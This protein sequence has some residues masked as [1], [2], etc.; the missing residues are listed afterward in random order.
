[1]AAQ[2]TVNGYCEPRFAGVKDAFLKNLESG[3]EVGASFAATINGKFVVDIWG[4]YTNET[5]TLPWEK[6]T[7]VNTYST[8]KTMTTVCALMLVDQGLL[9]LNAPITKYWPEFGQNGKENMP[10]HYLF[11]HQ[12]GLAGWEEPVKV[13]D[14]YNWEK[15][16]ALLAAQKPWWEP[17]TRSGY[18]AV[19]YGYL[20]GE[21]VRRITGKSLGTFFREEIAEPL[22]ADFHIGLPAEHDARVSILIPAP[23]PPAPTTPPNPNRTYTE[24]ASIPYKVFSNPV[25]TT[26]YLPTRT[27]RAAEIPASN[28]HGNARS[29]ARS[30]SMLA[31]GGELD[32]IKF[33]SEA[34][35]Q[36]MT[37]EQCYGPDLVLF[38]PIRW[39]LGFALTSKEIKMGP[40]P[41]SYWWGGYG[42]SRVVIDPDTRMCCAYVMNQI[43]EGL[44]GDVRS[45]RLI[46][47]LYAGMQG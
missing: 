3:Y 45:M 15:M 37:Q 5:K 38:M 22:H 34:T 20:L 42:G 24:R 8:T 1:M 23:P 27:W 28:G 2:L 16:T 21:I 17:G 25:V 4:G 44:T 12:S 7:I 33:L 10:V 43:R 19:S 6:D 40:N 13:E 32:G 14:F 18:H 30:N 11:S 47:A 41:N 9:D 39:G 46:N 26:K 36:K 31:C 29:V 35:L